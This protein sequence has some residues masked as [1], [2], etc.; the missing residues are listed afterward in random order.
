M[1]INEKYFFCWI[2]FCVAMNMTDSYKLKSEIAGFCFKPVNLLCLKNVMWTLWCR[3]SAGLTEIYWKY[4]ASV[5]HTEN[6]TENGNKRKKMGF[7]KNSRRQ[8]QNDDTATNLFS[9]ISMIKLQ[10]MTSTKG[11]FWRRR[12]GS[13]RM[14]LIS[15]QS[16]DSRTVSKDSIYIFYKHI[17]YS[18]LWFPN[19]I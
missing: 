8:T 18:L 12:A 1:G 9:V 7:K 16:A 15:N 19:L 10:N 2:F 3:E 13:S 6:T 5:K 4:T 11:R 17:C 14:S